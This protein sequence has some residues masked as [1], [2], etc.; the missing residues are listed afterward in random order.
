LTF[1]AGPL[2]RAAGIFAACYVI[3]AFWPPYISVV[4]LSLIKLSKNCEKGAAVGG[5]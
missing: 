1:P 3:A 4:F 5:F 2:V